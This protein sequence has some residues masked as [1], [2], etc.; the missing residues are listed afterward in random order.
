MGLKVLRC[1]MESSRVSEDERLG[2]GD[3]F[4]GDLCGCL[5]YV[6]KL[7]FKICII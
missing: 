4:G 6:G 5:L 3:V 7:D 2:Y 1:R